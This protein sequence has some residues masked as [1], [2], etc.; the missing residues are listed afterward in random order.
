MEPSVQHFIRGATKPECLTM[1][2]MIAARLLEIEPR[3]TFRRGDLIEFKDK[4]GLPVRATVDRVNDKTLSC[5]CTET[6]GKWRV[7]PHLARL[8]GADKKTTPPVAP[9]IV[10][11]IESAAAG[12]TVP[13]FGSV[14][15]SA[16][17]G[18]W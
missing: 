3:T 17:A 9:M 8:V 15:T 18:G 11:P 5:T 1:Q 7:S 13:G 2:A 10:P 16:Y 6:R 12:S 4:K 14:P